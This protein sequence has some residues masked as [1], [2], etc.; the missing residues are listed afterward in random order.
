MTIQLLDH[1]N[2]CTR[3]L[4]ACMKFYSD[5]LGFEN[6]PRPELGVPGAWM[7]CGEQA[8]IHI[9]AFDEAPESYNFV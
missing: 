9:M 8:V 4:D 3:D 6:G 2:I 1:V 5:I 7:Y